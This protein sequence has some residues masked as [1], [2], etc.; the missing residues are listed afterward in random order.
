MKKVILNI[1]ISFCLIIGT[2]FI[3]IYNLK[4]ENIEITEDGE[5]ITINKQ[6]YFYEF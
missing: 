5:I 4:I 1:F 3:T 6:K 2:Y